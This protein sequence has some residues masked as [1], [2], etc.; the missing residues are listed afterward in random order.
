VRTVLRQ[1]V[2]PLAA[3]ALLWLSVGIAVSIGLEVAFGHDVEKRFSPFSDVQ[4]TQAA[5]EGHYSPLTDAVFWI[6]AVLVGSFAFGWVAFFIA[7][8]EIRLRFWVAVAPSLLA[9][10]ALAL[11]FHF[12]WNDSYPSN[13]RI[14]FICQLVIYVGCA[15]VGLGL[16]A[17]ALAGRRESG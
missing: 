5:S 4:L 17:H 15:L 14:A 8:R 1:I 2:L 13:M 7:K 3:I 12:I 16:G 9:V 6:C 11:R 10:A